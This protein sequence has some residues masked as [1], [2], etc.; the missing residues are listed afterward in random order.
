LP[1]ENNVIY[2]GGSGKHIDWR[3]VITQIC[4]DTSEVKEE[5]K[6]TT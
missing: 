2:F 5:N 1:D 6:I 4:G 3:F